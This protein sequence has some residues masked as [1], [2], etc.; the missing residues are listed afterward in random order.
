MKKRLSLILAIMII[1]SSLPM[2]ELVAFAAEGDPAFTSVIVTKIYR[3]LYG[4]ESYNILVTGDNFTVDGKNI[5]EVG[6]MGE[7]NKVKAFTPTYSSKTMLQY[8]LEPEQMSGKIFI[9]GK[10]V[11]ISENDM[12]F[13]TNKE[14]TTGMVDSTT[15]AKITLT[16]SGFD[17][18]TDTLKAYLFQGNTK[19]PIEKGTSST[20]LESTELKGKTGTWSVEFEKKGTINTLKKADKI[21]NADL[22]IS[23]RYMSMF[24]VLNKLDVSENI[25]LI[26]TQGP[27]ESIAMLQAERL[28]REHEMSVFFLKGL[29]EPYLA[30]HMAINEHYRRDDK[31]KKDIFSFTVPKALTPG[32][33]YVVL[34]NEVDPTKDI[35]SQIKSYK[36]LETK[37]IVIDRK[38]MVLIDSIDPNKGS[39]KG[40]NAIIKGINIA[41]ISPDIY[42]NGQRDGDIDIKTNTNKMIVKYKDGT[43]KMIGENGVQVK[44]LTREIKFIIGGEVTFREGSDLGKEE[45][46]KVYDYINVRV[47]ENFDKEKLVYDVIAEITTK[48]EYIEKDD[49]GNDVNKTTEIFE[50]FTLKNGF[51]YEALDY[52]PKITSIVPDKIPVD[53]NFHA[54]EG[55][56]VAI[57]GE[58]FLL[59]R[60]KDENGKI[61]YRYP[62]FDFGGQFKIDPN[63]D[64]DIEI[65]ILN[66]QGNEIDGT[67]DNHLGS[68]IL[69]TIPAGKEI[70]PDILNN[71]ID[72][73]VT[74]PI[75]VPDS[76]DEGSSATY[77]F[78]FIKPEGDKTP[79]ITSVTPDTITT[80]GEKGIIISGQN[81]AE[82]FNLYMDGEKITSAKRNGTGT[83]ITF[84]A[85]PK[86]EGYVQLI[87]QNDDGALA[88]YDKL[89]YVKTYTD[90][91]II[92]FNPKKGTANTLVDLKGQNL[93]PPNPLV[94]DSEG[95][96]FMKL[97]GTRIFLG[98]KDINTYTTDHK[99]K[100]YTTPSDKPII[101][102]ENNSIIPSDYY[103]SIILEDENNKVYYKIYFD[104]VSGK[105]YLTNGDKDVYEIIAD[106]NT[107]YGK[108]GG[109]PQIEI[110]ISQKDIV[111]LGDK[112]LTIKTPYA[113]EIKNREEIITGNRVKVINSNELYFEVPPQPREGYYD[114]AI[115]NPDTKKD[116]RKGNA[117]F[118]Y[119]FQPGDEPPKIEE[120]TPSEGSTEGQYTI[121]ISGKN[122]VDRGPNEKTS[123]IIGGITVPPQDVVVAPN[124]STM[125]VKVPKYPGDL[126][127]E[128]DMDRKYVNV[129]VINPDG[130]SDRRINGF[131]YIIPI[132][133][134]KITK[135]ILNKG[136]AAGGDIVTIEGS[137]FRYFEPFRDA[138]NNGTFDDDGSETFTDKNGNK[139]WDDLRNKDKYNELLK[140]EGGW[141]KNILPILPTVYFGGKVAKIKSFTASTIDVE[142]PKG[143]K[144]S[145]EVYLVNN[146]YG[147]SNKLIF[148][149]ESSA[150]K[151]NSITPNTG[152]KQG[153]DKLEILGEGFIKGDIL[154]YDDLKSLPKLK[155]IVQIQFAKP[156]DENMTNINLPL[157]NPNSGRIRD[158]IAQ[159]KA[160]QLELKYNATEKDVKLSITL[161]DN[162]IKYTAENILYNNEEVFFPL[163]LLKNDKGEN[164]NGNELVRIR[165]E[166]IE[167]ASNTFRVRLDRGFSP[168]AKVLN[169]GHINVITPSYYTIGEVEV[170]LT[171]PDNGVATGKFN[172]KNPDSK[173]KITN[174]LRDGQEGYKVEDG[175]T[176]VEVNYLGGNTIEII[177]QDFRKPVKIQIGDITINAKIEYQPE[178][179]S[180]SNRLIFKM[181]AIENR[182]IGTYN[183]VVVENEDGGVANSEPIFIKF[184]TPESTGLTITKA[185]PNFGPTSGG[186]VITI[187]GKDFREKM[188]GIPNGKL[189]VY[190]GEGSKQVQVPQENI[191]SIAYDKIILKT[192]PYTAGPATIKV[193]NPDGNIA[194]LPNGFNYVS[195]PKITSVVNPNNNK[196]LVETLSIEGGEKIKIIGS[197]FMEGAKVVFNPVLKLV[198]D[199]TPA[200]G[201]VI[202]IG[203]KKYILESGTEGTEVEVVNGQTI[204]VITPEGKL[205]DK[206]I[207]VI[208]P[209]KGA[210]D[211]YNIGYGIPDMDAPFNVEAEVVYDQFIKVHWSGVKDAFE[212]EIYMSEDGDK[213]EFIGTTELTSYVVQNIKSR[214]EYQFLVRAIGKYGTSKPIDESKSNYV[215]TGRGVG[216][217][218]ED[219]SLGENTLINR[220]GTMADIS[221]GTEDFNSKGM[222][223]DLTRGELAGVK[224]IT[225]RIPAEIVVN[226]FG[227]IKVLG[228]DY[229]M[230]FSPNIFKNSTM[231][232]NRKNS[233]AGVVFKVSAYKGNTNV[234]S[235]EAI[236]GETY[237]L[238]GTTYVDKDISKIDYLRGNIK[239]TL[240]TDTQK[241]QN[242]RLN[243][244]QMVRYDENTKTWVPV[245][246]P[247]RLG[248]YTVIGSRR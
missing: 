171:N 113:T 173:P 86:P 151:I 62:K 121:T 180:I 3:D 79:F 208:N 154:V 9:D 31:L 38:N 148:T 144:G 189:K 221:I 217:E 240:D 87:V 196:V 23:H 108:K 29:D 129:I 104:T 218:D 37:F 25:D 115:V 101:S 49:K 13:I 175:R 232:D 248:L 170:N 215:T 61:Q 83:Q 117:G 243:R 227:N 85:P 192:P 164:Y 124:G 203:T 128:T 46:K 159:A 190:F 165:L 220:N 82:K 184:T 234:K 146:D 1:L 228:K 157:D 245:N 145:A 96:G 195:N 187:E 95:V 35:K 201:E 199:K 169:Q 56:K 163:N 134:P 182:Y 5:V 77:K 132:S 219:G 209:D 21:T 19:L 143:V 100:E 27:V 239:F 149:Y 45:D 40:V 214:T 122:F 242:R 64:E 16:G 225:I 70:N 235:G 106:K 89:L 126:S 133:H 48:I 74:N 105:Y 183:R 59:Y 69:L 131:A 39:S 152:R 42:E 47:G 160:G 7:D 158:K 150:P 55:L 119:F 71:Q 18:L 229:T 53:S 111:K 32:S 116:E 246:Y 123:V 147:V 177:G 166:K 91:K 24:S 72:L 142:V 58:N 11:D 34:T 237:L 167:G 41:R 120:I 185:T 174:I 176:I 156:N 57:I 103:H 130:G 66:K 20:K 81:F 202:T 125:T 230:E 6:I 109:D 8:E 204:T 226:S 54:M 135:L 188:D 92:D 247:N 231:E 141:D 97:I 110:D 139:K 194:E 178:E 168:E 236:V 241:V 76:K 210:T 216:P 213:F 107:L 12:P 28:K 181:P 186:T 205:D 14:P 68:K 43:Y 2:G 36:V 51:T 224:D 94:K 179:D 93:V 162:D 161:T 22:T 153:G 102:A 67:D 222:T 63:E 198:D 33:Y 140:E 80:S 65:R 197:D 223:I 207:I 172:Y 17:K 114:I 99:L 30:S 84:D 50:T 193:E 206:G 52:V 212:Y 98:G 136:S 211:V 118:Y 127:K 60:Y 90:P 244:V 155:E 44:N 233:N 73:K 112:T 10:E 4:V 137:D 238:E 88:T 75:R 26:P 200:T 138:N 15:D 191:I 78:Q